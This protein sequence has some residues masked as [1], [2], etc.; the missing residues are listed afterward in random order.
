MEGSGASVDRVGSST[1]IAS[2]VPSPSAV[3][4]NP[5]GPHPSGGR[6]PQSR[7]PRPAHHLLSRRQGTDHR[8]PFAP[9]FAA[10]VSNRASPPGSQIL[11]TTLGP[12]PATKPGIIWAAGWHSRQAQRQGA[13]EAILINNENHW[14]ET[15][16]G[17]SGAGS[18]A[19]GGPLPL[20]GGHSPPASPRSLVMASLLQQG[21]VVRE[22]PWTPRRIDRFETLAYNQRRSSGRP[23]PHSP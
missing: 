13:K 1:A 2:A 3:G 18:T 9:G 22:D 4:P 8:S 11:L 20:Q 10:A 23:Y 5:T 19:P 21:F 6:S 12:S 14:L 7:V 15:S 17:T 16:T